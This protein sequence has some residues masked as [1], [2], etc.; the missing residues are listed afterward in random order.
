MTSASTALKITTR[1]TSLLGTV[2]AG[3]TRPGKLLS[4]KHRDSTMLNIEIRKPN[5]FNV[6][7]LNFATP[8]VSPEWYS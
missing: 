7:F 3:E 2:F 4:G 8:L 5:S 6:G 1:E